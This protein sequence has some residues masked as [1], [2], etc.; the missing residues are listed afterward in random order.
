MSG[1][2]FPTGEGLRLAGKGRFPAIA[3][4][5]PIAREPLLVPKL[6]TWH[7]SGAAENSVSW[8]GL[9]FWR[10]AAPHPPK[11]EPY[12]IHGTKGKGCRVGKT[13]SISAAPMKAIQLE[14]PQHFIPL[15]V[16]EPATPGPGEAL[17]RVHRV[18]ICGTV[19]SWKGG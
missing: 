9:G 11:T 2:R 16:P 13:R 18:G 19:S 4:F 3:S 7:A 12:K 8:Q 1:G 6:R 5:F 15:D 17:V 14:R 10:V